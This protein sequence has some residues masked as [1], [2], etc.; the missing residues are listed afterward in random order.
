MKLHDDVMSDLLTVYLADDVSA[1]TKTL[2]ET[3][4]AENSVFAE[5]LAA[6]RALSLHAAAVPGPPEDAELKSLKHTR[7]VLFLRT[8][9]LAWA[10]LFMLLPLLFTFDNGSV[11]FVIW[12]RYPALVS[13]FWSLAAASWVAWYVMRR[14]VRQSGL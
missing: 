9:F 6:A 12:G 13:S 11:Q 14:Q 3:H 8:M 7:Q 10:V 5:R 2:V 4:A 1:E